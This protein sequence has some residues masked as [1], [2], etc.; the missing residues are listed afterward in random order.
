MSRADMAYQ[1]EVVVGSQPQPMGTS[2][3]FSSQGTWTSDLCDCCSDMG[4]CLCGTFVPCVL[5]C[6]VSEQAGECCCLPYLPGT[7][8]ALRTGVR[9]R[10]HIEGSICDDWVVMACCPLCGL[11]QLARELNNKN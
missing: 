8:I 1:T 9:E 11:C 10:Y 7:L 4:I 2:Y 6:R 5:A 3:T